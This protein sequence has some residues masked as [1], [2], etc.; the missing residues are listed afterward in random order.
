MVALPEGCCAICRARN[1]CKAYTWTDHNTGTCWLKS[2]KGAFTTKTGA[3]SA[4][5]SS[6][7]PTCTLVNNVDYNGNDIGNSPSAAA[8]G[9]C[10]ICR[11]RTGCRVFTWSNYNGGTCWLK[12]QQGPGT[13]VA[14]AVSGTI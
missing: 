1:D 4:R 14:G 3:R 9:C 6:T 11:G 13:T 2:G 5:V 12:S 8:T 7:S 10:D